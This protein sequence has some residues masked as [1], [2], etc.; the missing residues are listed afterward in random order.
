MQRKSRG[1][2]EGPTLSSLPRA[3]ESAPRCA[4]RALTLPSSPRMSPKLG[5]AG[6]GWKEKSESEEGAVAVVAAVSLVG[7]PGAESLL[8]AT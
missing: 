7:A 3:D 2:D 8:A 4:T 1:T 6:R 5:S